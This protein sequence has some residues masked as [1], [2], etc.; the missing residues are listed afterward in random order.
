MPHRLFALFLL[1][2][3]GCGGE[4]DPDPAPE[5]AQVEEIAARPPV[6]SW[7]RFSGSLW[8]GQTGRTVSLVFGAPG[9]A[10]RFRA[11]GVNL[12]TGRIVYHVEGS[13]LFDYSLFAIKDLLERLVP[14]LPFVFDPR[15]WHIATQVRRPFPPPNPVGEPLLQ[16]ARLVG[17]VNTATLDPAVGLRDLDVPGP[18]GLR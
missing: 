12:G 1:V 14:S 15:D 18:G 5:L 6:T 10:D 2:T 17:L 3:A 4:L 8:R 7:D 16:L 11:V 13:W 9:H